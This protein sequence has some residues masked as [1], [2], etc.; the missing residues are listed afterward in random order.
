MSVSATNLPAIWSPPSPGECSR[1]RRR[2]SA[3]TP[4]SRRRNRSWP[5]SRWS[6]LKRSRTCP[7]CARWPQRTCGRLKRTD[8]GD[9]ASHRLRVARDAP[10]RT[11]SV[12]TQEFTDARI[13]YELPRHCRADDDLS[14]AGRGRRAL[15]PAASLPPTS[16]VIT[17]SASI[18]RRSSPPGR[19]RLGAGTRRSNRSGGTPWCFAPKTRAPRP[20][21]PRRPGRAIDWVRS[22]R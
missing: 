16:E 14:R 8:V 11:D 2:R 15:Q 5:P 22:R 13:Q 10:A 19:S 1:P 6:C 17:I 3:I 7:A 21:R 20:R 4:R 12:A 9:L 18:V